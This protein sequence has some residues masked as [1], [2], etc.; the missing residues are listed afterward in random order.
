MP[1]HKDNGDALCTRLV[2]GLADERAAY[3]FA[4]MLRH[5]SHG[6][7]SRGT[8]GAPTA[9]NLQPAQQHMPYDNAVQFGN[10]RHFIEH[11]IA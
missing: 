2:E 10:Q 11:L 5:Y 8:N 3:A 7:E 6:P 9:D 4:L 1:Q